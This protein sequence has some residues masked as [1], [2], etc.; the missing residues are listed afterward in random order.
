[1]GR[2]HR[3]IDLASG[4]PKM[5]RTRS[6]PAVALGSLLLLAAGC[7]MTPFSRPAPPPRPAAF[8]P[9]GIAAS[10]VNSDVIGGR[11]ARA[12]KLKAAKIRPLSAAEAPGYMYRAEQELRNQTAGIGIDVIRL[13]DGI[14]IRV[15]AALTFDA[16]SAAIKPQID[17]TLTEVA[18]TLKTFNQTYVD[19]L[20]HTDT[21]GTPQVNLALS[22]KRASAAAAFLGSH[23]V[24]KSRIAAKGFG[25]S[26]PLYPLDQAE[27]QRA[28]NRRVE[29]RLVPFGG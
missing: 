17:A 7:S 2:F 26:A 15:P 20:A 24:A 16:G 29:I 10:Y 18:R 9:L 12:A 11:K 4:A 13:P 6:I 1:M 8:I 19:V 3:V 22:Q 21:S 27:E 5:D 28:A 23:G 14:L 25:E